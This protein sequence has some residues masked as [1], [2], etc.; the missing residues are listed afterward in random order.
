MRYELISRSV[1]FLFVGEPLR[2]LVPFQY[3]NAV[4]T[5]TS[6]SCRTTAA[7]W[8]V[9]LFVW[10]GGADALLASGLLFGLGN[11]RGWNLLRLV[12]LIA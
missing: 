1:F 2:P 9:F 11:N 6:S 10:E 7:L 3:F 12:L 4:R 5:D 8:H